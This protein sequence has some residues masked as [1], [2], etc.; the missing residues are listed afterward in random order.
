MCSLSVKY[1]LD[2][3]DLALKKDI[4]YLIYILH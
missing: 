4:N 1:V 3:K 2:F